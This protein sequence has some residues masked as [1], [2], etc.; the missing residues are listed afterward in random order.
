[1]IKEFKFVDIDN[2]GEISVS[3]VSKFLQIYSTESSAMWNDIAALSSL[4]AHTI[5]EY[6]PDTALKIEELP[7]NWRA[8]PRN[9]SYNH[10]SAMLNEVNDSLR[11]TFDGKIIKDGESKD[12]PV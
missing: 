9:L 7:H 8:G 10:F 12:E 6:R 11:K 1:M 4:I 2:D 5:A 3:D